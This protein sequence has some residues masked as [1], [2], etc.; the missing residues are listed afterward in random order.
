MADFDQK[1]L[2][3]YIRTEELLKKI[4]SNSVR[5]TGDD[6]ESLSPTVISLVKGLDLFLTGTNE[7]RNTEK[8]LLEFWN[9]LIKK[10]NWT[11]PLSDKRNSLVF[12]V[13]PISKLSLVP[14]KGDAGILWGKLQQDLK[15]TRLDYEL[16]FNIFPVKEVKEGHW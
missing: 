2:K 13:T 12:M 10:E 9:L 8:D 16:I 1:F 4:T 14:V 6:F 15:E 11:A 3:D 5:Y 7:L